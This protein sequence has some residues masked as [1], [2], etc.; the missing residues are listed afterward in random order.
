MVLHYVEWN[1]KDTSK[2]TIDCFE[3]HREGHCLRK[4]KQGHTRFHKFHILS[5]SPFFHILL[6]LPHSVKHRWEHLKG[7]LWGVCTCLRKGSLYYRHGCFL[8]YSVIRPF[9]NL[10]DPYEVITYISRK[11][12]YMVNK[13]QHLLPTSPENFLTI[14]WY[15]D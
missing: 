15:H 12:G 1:I 10:V 6:P 13:G 8:V 7:S 9:P 3:G 14:H 11:G 2:M 5:F 4:L